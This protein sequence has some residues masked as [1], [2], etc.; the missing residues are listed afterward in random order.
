MITQLPWM[1]F[2]SLVLIGCAGYNV[3]LKIAG[4]QI[5]I[6]LFSA[7]L[8]VVASIGHFLILF[9]YKYMIS[10]GEKLEFTSVG[11]YMGVLA[12][13]A[14]ILIDIGLFMAIKTGGLV[15]SQSVWTVGGLILSVIIG[16]YFFKEGFDVYK[17]AGIVLG[18]VAL[19]LLMRQG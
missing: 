14:V 11:L 15:V 13:V 19:G 17:A 16:F 9:I 7:I 8:T 18:I 1:F 10:N 2:I 4:D 5:N 12:G 3:A 6:F